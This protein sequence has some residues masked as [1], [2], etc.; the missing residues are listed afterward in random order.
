MKLKSM[1]CAYYVC[2]CMANINGQSCCAGG[3]GSCSMGGGGYNILPDIERHVVGINYSLTSYSATVFPTTMMNINGIDMTM[4]GPGEAAK[5]YVNTLQIFGRFQ[6]PK[7][8][9]ISVSLPVSFL[10]ESSTTTANHQYG[11]GDASAS[12]SYTIINPKKYQDKKNKHQVKVGFGV[13]APTGKFA[14]T[15]DGLFT[16]DLQL[17]TGS[18]DFLFNASYTYRYKKFGASVMSLYKKNLANNKHY[19]FGDKA[20]ET[21]QSFMVFS[22]KKSITISPTLSASYEH[23]FYNVYQKKELSYTG[24]D[25]LSAAA[26][27]DI[28]YKH[29]AL[30]AKVCPVLF[31]INHWEGEPIPVLSLETGLF[32]NF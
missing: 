21:L 14:M 13:K 10:N 24:S 19:R 3:S 9:Q 29:F 26:G 11:L 32:Y 18:V 17:G 2:M 15:N 28:Y 20:K 8:F 22:L 16:N 25:I 1:L 27:L 6:L 30:S 23:N 4:T 7:R 31:S 5:G 12:V